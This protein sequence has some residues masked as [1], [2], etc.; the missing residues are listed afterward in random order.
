MGRHQRPSGKGPPGVTEKL[1]EELSGL[2]LSPDALRRRL[3]PLLDYRAD[4]IPWLLR[5]FESEDEG[6]LAFAT[7][8]L[9]VIDDPSLVPLLLKLLRSSNVDDLAK[10]LLLNLLE[11]YGLNIHDPS[12]ISASVD[13]RE[14]FRGPGAPRES[15]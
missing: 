5:Q 6:R 9:K 3:R 11:H 13:L 4:V 10:G 8:A 15:E 14:A 7:S 12:L 2:A 1:L